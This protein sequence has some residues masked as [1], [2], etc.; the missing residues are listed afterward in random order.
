MDR[1]LVALAIGVFALG[2]DSYIVAAMRGRPS[3]GSAAFQILKNCS[4]GDEA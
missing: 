2:A 1:R 3:V 4:K